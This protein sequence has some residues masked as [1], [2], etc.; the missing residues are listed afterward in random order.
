MNPCRRR[1]FFV[2]KISLTADDNFV[3]CTSH[4]LSTVQKVVLSHCT[5]R[6]AV[7]AGSQSNNF[8][9]VS[10]LLSAQFRLH[11]LCAG[12]CISRLFLLSPFGPLRES[13]VWFFTVNHKPG[14]IIEIASR[15]V[16]LPLF[17]HFVRCRN[18]DS[19]WVSY[20]HFSAIQIISFRASADEVIP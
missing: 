5:V 13:G 14:N 18:C 15:N 1:N 6:S 2:H 11:R 8:R 4:S 3:Y 7:C 17:Y 20:S 9:F 16:Y 10:A 12:L 19:P